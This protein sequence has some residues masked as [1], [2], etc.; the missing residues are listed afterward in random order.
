M[1]LPRSNHLQHSLTV[2]KLNVE[3]NNPTSWY[4][5]TSYKLNVSSKPHGGCSC[6]SKRGLSTWTGSRMT[7][8]TSLWACLWGYLSWVNSVWHC[9]LHWV[10]GWIKRLRKLSTRVHLSSWWHLWQ[11]ASRTPTPTTTMTSLHEP[12]VKIISSLH[13]FYQMFCPSSE[14]G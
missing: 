7:T 8:E 1:I 4:L 11:T 6:D 3:P 9:S 13:F 2:R 12:G 10:P 14:K 5:P